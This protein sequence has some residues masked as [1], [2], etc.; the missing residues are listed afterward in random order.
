MFQFDID[1]GGSVEVVITAGTDSEPAESADMEEDHTIEEFVK[2]DTTVDDSADLVCK[3]RFNFAGQIFSMY[4][5][6]P[7]QQHAVYM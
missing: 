7:Y 4:L 6:V 5:H 3:V 2:R 1:T